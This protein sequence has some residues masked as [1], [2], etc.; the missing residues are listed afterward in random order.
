LGINGAGKS[1]L[2]NTLSDVHEKFSAGKITYQGGSR[3]FSDEAFKMSRYTVFTEEQAF[4]YWA[5]DD[6][7]DF[8]AKAHKKALD[9]DY[10][11]YLIGGFSFSE[12]RKYEI[13]DWQQEKGVSDY[14]FCSG[15]TVADSGRAA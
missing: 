6:Y 8:I 13:K 4:M 9:R 3:K 2:I 14:G 5:F 12:Y 11:D 7:I 1:T 15:V 10:V